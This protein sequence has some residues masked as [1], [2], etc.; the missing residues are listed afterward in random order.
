MS[1]ITWSHLESLQIN[2]SVPLLS[3]IILFGFVFIAG[4]IL[5]LPLLEFDYKKALKS[6]LFIKIFFWIPIFLI[7]IGVLYSSGF[8]RTVFL[9]LLLIVAFLEFRFKLKKAENKTAAYAYFS[10]FAIG[11][12][13]FFLLGLFFD[14][15]FVNLIITLCFATALSDIGA[16]L[17][18]K[19]LGKHKLPEWINNSKSWEGVVGQLLGSLVGILLVN[20]FVTPVVTL[21]IFLPI[22][23]GCIIGDLANSFAKRNVHADNWSRAIPG[24]GGFID[25]LSSLAGS[26]VLMF[27]FLI[28]T[29]LL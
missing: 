25:R 21:W 15:F 8:D 12:G 27:Y 5:C 2:S 11:L 20:F 9:V 22:G 4:V 6:S 26:T 18:G 7:F 23:I 16:F 19:Y 28:L 14:K 29:G 1:G 10:L 24:H 13:H 17:L 3:L